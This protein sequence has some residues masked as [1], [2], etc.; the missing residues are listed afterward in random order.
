[1]A[2]GE[3]FTSD[4]YETRVEQRRHLAQCPY[5]VKKE[6]PKTQMDFFLSY[7]VQGLRSL[8]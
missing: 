5:L 8:L 1:M 3:N 2:L 7:S 4:T 6:F